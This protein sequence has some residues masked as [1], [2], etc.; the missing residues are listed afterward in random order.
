MAFEVLRSVAGLKFD[1]RVDL[2]DSD[3]TGDPLGKSGAVEGTAGRG[4]QKI[5]IFRVAAQFLFHPDSGAQVPAGFPPSPPAEPGACDT[6]NRHDHDQLVQFP[7]F[8]GTGELVE[9]FESVQGDQTCRREAGDGSRANQIVD[10]RLDLTAFRA[11]ED[12]EAL[13]S[14]QGRLSA[15][16]VAVRLAQDALSVAAHGR[17]A[18]TK[19][20]LCAPL[21]IRSPHRIRLWL[22]IEPDSPWITRG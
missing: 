7:V 11:R 1:T 9:R 14:L 22:K 18:D 8:M 20:F 3:L 16:S 4:D 15:V 2:K 17:L 19:M 6:E 13:A 5:Q 12:A 10:P 21:M